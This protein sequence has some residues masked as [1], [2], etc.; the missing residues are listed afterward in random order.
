MNME[1]IDLLW[2][3]SDPDGNPIYLESYGSLPQHG[4]LIDG[5]TAS[6]PFRLDFL[7]SFRKSS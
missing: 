6:T 1:E 3:D 5:P 7:I 2:N 4:R